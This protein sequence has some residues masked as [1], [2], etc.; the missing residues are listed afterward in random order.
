MTKLLSP[1]LKASPAKSLPLQTFFVWTFRGCWSLM[2]LISITAGWGSFS[3]SV[4]LVRLDTNKTGENAAAA[5]VVGCSQRWDVLVFS[6]DGDV[7]CDRY[8]SHT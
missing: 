5:A 6:G 2:R 3:S 1:S 8:L 7:M 4:K